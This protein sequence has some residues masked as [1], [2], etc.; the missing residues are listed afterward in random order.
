MFSTYVRGSN[1]ARLRQRRIAA[2][3]AVARAGL[4]A[5]EISRILLLVLVGLLA[6]FAGLMCY[7]GRYDVGVLVVGGILFFSLAATNYAR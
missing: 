3:R 2:R 5:A 1:P 7:T 6:L 4:T